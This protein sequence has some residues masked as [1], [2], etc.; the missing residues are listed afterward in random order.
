MS[1]GKINIIPNDKPS[2]KLKKLREEEGLT[3]QELANFI[4]CS[5]KEML[6]FEKDIEKIPSKYHN[7]LAEILRTVPTT[8]K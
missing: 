3:Q 5:L 6:D 1:I 8:F 4:G 7:K 2:K